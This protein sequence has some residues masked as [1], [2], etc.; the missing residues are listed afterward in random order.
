MH[1]VENQGKRIVFAEGFNFLVFAG[2]EGES[3]LGD[4]SYS[5]IGGVKWEIKEIY[6]LGGITLPPFGIKISN[7]LFLSIRVG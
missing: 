3:R 1:Q 6:T 5:R 4:R 7:F 2:F